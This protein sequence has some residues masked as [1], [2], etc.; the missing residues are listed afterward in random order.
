MIRWSARRLAIALIAVVYLAA[1]LESLHGYR[2]ERMDAENQL[3][4]S[5]KAVA[6][7][8]GAVLRNAN[9]LLLSV[10]EWLGTGNSLSSL[11]A[12]R[13]LERLSVS[14][15]VD[16]AIVTD[17]NGKVLFSSKAPL[18]SSENV[19]RE[20]LGF[21]REHLTEQTAHV[22]LPVK[23]RLT[24]KT[25]IPVTW[26]RLT[27]NGSFAGVISTGLKPEFLSEMLSNA[28]VQ[29]SATAALLMEDGTV[30][31]SS[32][33]SA[34]NLGHAS[35]REII[36][37]G[38]FSFHQEGFFVNDAARFVGAV[39]VPGYPL[40]VVCTVSVADAMESWLREVTETFGTAIPLSIAIFIFALLV[41]R[42][43]RDRRNSETNLRIAA[44]AFESQ[45]GIVITDT[46]GVILRVNRAF[47]EDTGYSAEEAVGQTPRILKSGRHDDAFY[48][49]MWQSLLQNGSW[50]GEIWDRRKSG[51]IFPKWLNIT[52]V[53]GADGAATHYVASHMDITERKA[54]EE[55]IKDLGLYDPLTRLPNRR[56]MMDRLRQSL[57]VSIRGR[58][59]GALFFVDLDNFKTL[60]DTHGHDKGDQ[61]LVEVAQ[62]LTTSVRELDTVARLGGD[63]FVVILG[64]LAENPEDAVARATTIAEKII[65]AVGQPYQISGHHYITTPSIGIAMFGYQRESIDELM[66]QADIA[67]YQAKAAGRNTMRF[68]DP[69]LQAIIKARTELEDGIRQGISRNEFFLLYQPQLEGDQLIGTE[70]LIRWRHPDRGLVSPIEF[71][72]LA[73][74]TGLILP[75]GRWV[76]E[77]ACRQIV[78]WASRPETAH[79]T[80]AVNVSARQFQAEDFVEEV[81]A[82]LDRTGADPH[83][84]KL[85][86]TES[87]L[88]HHIEAVI[89][90]MTTLKSHGLRFSLDDFGTG[91]SSL[92]YL[93]RLPLTQLK[94]DRSFVMDVLSDPNDAAIARTVIALGQSL[95]LE[96]IA[97]G[98][99]TEGQRDFLAEHGCHACQGYLFGRPVS[100][101]EVERLMNKPVQVINRPS[102]DLTQGAI[103]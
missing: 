101:E 72:P 102:T 22:S 33:P 23:S 73:E 89:A 87:M 80:V 38:A 67:M 91:Y 14:P 83:Q 58:H 75:L 47:I 28:G 103:T 40:V 2:D 32:S 96:V 7:Q 78:A 35:Y 43:E 12:T 24:G 1:T 82:A 13:L 36:E 62:R 92:S 25:I 74:E 60:N 15:S 55:K 81:L 100:A 56:L 98:V 9:L 3:S 19:D 90:K 61:L 85:E 34:A 93:K 76:L 54:A 44:T 4:A 64:A 94:I 41:D 45:E 39:P 27:P 69:A 71:I 21:W 8:V 5:S 29:P 86:L 65:R 51:E 26:P 11:D 20:Y 97:E 48:A 57:A 49:Q 52:A 50:Q 30:L 42:R 59:E 88:V 17:A 79:I 68:F 16:A 95:G 37:H 10:S 31:A 84:L 18:K 53:R 70:A 77:T 66:K 46:N 6:A 63:E 99:E